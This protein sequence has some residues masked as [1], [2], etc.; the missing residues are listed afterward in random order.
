MTMATYTH[1]VV[2]KLVTQT[3]EAGTELVL[4]QLTRLVL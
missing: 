2:A 3:E 1:R 4:V